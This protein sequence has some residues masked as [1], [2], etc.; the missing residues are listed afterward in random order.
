MTS[1]GE[2][3]S[4]TALVI[5]GAGGF[6]RE[7]IDLIDQIDPTHECFHII[8]VVATEP[9]PQSSR[10]ERMPPYLGNDDDFLATGVDASFVVAVG[11][12]HGFGWFEDD[13]GSWIHSLF[14]HVHH[15][16]CNGRSICA[17]RQVVNHRAR[18]RHR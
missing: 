4:S 3:N 13:L 17:R 7:S 16:G 6:Y 15:H 10:D 2:G 14:I 11:S 8:G 5:L 12:P 9:H 18:L 1:I